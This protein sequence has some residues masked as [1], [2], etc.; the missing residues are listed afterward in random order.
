MQ[1]CVCLS[2]DFAIRD[3]VQRQTV[4]SPKS[5]GFSSFFLISMRVSMNVSPTQSFG[6]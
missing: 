2:I 6:E 1:R 5:N 3:L 4:Y